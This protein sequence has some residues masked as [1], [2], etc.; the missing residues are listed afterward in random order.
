LLGVGPQVPVGLF[1][2][3]SFELVIGALGILK[4]G[5]AYLP[6]DPTYPSERLS[7]ML[8]DADVSVL[9]TDQRHAERPPKG[10]WEVIALDSNWPLAAGCSDNA[11]AIGAKPE[12]L[13]YVIYT[14]GST[15][16]PKGVEVT[17]A[18][19]LNLVLWHQRAFTVTPT[20]RATQLASPGFDAAVW[21]LWPYL[22]AG[23]SVHLPDEA[24][25]VSP[26]ALRDWLVAQSITITFAPTALAERLVALKW[27]PNTSLRML[28]TGADA[29][30]RY[31][32]ADLPFTLVNNYGPTEGTV[33]ATSGPVL[34]W[35]RTDSP[36]PIGRP[37]D[38]TQIHI[39]DERLRQVSPGS[40]GELFIGGAGLAR[41]YRNRPELTAE[42]FIPNPFSSAPGDRLYRTGDL[43]RY[44]PDG[45]IAFLGR[46]DEQ[47]KVRGYRVEPNEIASALAQHAAIQASVVV[48]REDSADKRLV[49]YVVSAA[50]E[51]PT[52]TGLQ[53][54]LRERLPDYMVPAVFVRLQSLPLNASGKVDRAALPEP[55][56]TNVLQDDR[57]VL[58]RT[59]VES[60]VADILGT[61]LGVGR[62][63]VNDN[64]FLLGG[65][66]LLAGHVIARARDAFGVELTLR[67]LFD[68]PTVE[69]ISAE[70]ER[71]ILAKLEAMSED[72][73]RR[74]LSDTAL[75]GACENRQ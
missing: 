20:D 1:L 31:P 47:I 26:E 27:P 8:N 37:I 4:A 12:H 9:V 72:E 42:R 48:S 68:H 5:G 55:N 70:I 61:L 30:R 40:P 10:S 29:L 24:T 46:I 50:G 19:L 11:P 53:N 7:F 64:F 16:Q 44:L 58:P 75:P 13:A 18:S 65:H 56:P 3:R 66:S 45:Q 21:E 36:P 2:E 6:L 22:T 51:Q 33:V 25:R 60:R 54:F 39:L 23:A 57:L 63:G 49:A 71:L 52:P 35:D 73:V 62:V 32:P 34:P 15:G 41:G 14:S 59:Q 67:S 74:A 17:H 38:N 43:G 69:G 28:L